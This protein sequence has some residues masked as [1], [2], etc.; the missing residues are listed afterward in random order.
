MASQ[1]LAE[2]AWWVEGKT[3]RAITPRVLQAL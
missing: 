1:I 2:R 3:E